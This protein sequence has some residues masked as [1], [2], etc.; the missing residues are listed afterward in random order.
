MLPPASQASSTPSMAAG[1]G[2]T[3]AWCIG[4]CATTARSPS[5][6]G[7]GAT[8]RSAPSLRESLGVGG[9]M[10]APILHFE[11]QFALQGPSPP[12]NAVPNPLQLGG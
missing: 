2:A 3:T 5:P 9:W 10:D 12:T 7:G 4:T 6:S 11:L 8:C 1:G